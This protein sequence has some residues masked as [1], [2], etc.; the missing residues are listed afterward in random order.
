MPLSTFTAAHSLSVQNRPHTTRYSMH[1]CTGLDEEKKKMSGEF[2]DEEPSVR[3]LP[4]QIH[5]RL[6]TDCMY[7]NNSCYEYSSSSSSG[8]ATWQY[9]A[10][11]STQSVAA[12]YVIDTR[13]QTVLG[14]QACIQYRKIQYPTANIHEILTPP[15]YLLEH[16]GYHHHEARS[17]TTVV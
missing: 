16:P 10:C 3:K 12:R 1:A 7:N 5:T 15:V 11:C 6:D 4:L 2:H 13:K 14:F 8:I 17:T 9:T